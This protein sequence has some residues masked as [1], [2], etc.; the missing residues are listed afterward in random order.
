MQ[1][2]ICW[3]KGESELAASVRESVEYLGVSRIGHGFKSWEDQSV[4]TLL[5]ERNILLE[6]CPISNVRTG[7]ISS[8]KDHPVRK[9]YDAGVKICINTDDNGMF[10]T[11]ILEDYELMSREFGFEKEDFERCNKWALEASF[12]PKDIKDRV[13]AKYFVSK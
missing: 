6:I 2:R 1:V 5:K 8:I 4:V 7:S 13:E 3:P 9:L 11:S 12:L 10:G